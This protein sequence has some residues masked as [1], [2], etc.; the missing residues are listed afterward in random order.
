[1]KTFF[2]IAAVALSISANAQNV[3]IPDINFKNALLE[4]NPVIDTNGDNEIQVSEAA[5]FNG[6]MHISGRDVTDL[7]GIEAFTALETLFCTNNQLT[8]LNI[9]SNTALKK[10]DCSSNQLTSLDVSN[11]TALTSLYCNNNELTGLDVSNNTALESLV[12]PIN[13]LTSL[14]VSNNIALTYLY[15]SDNP[16]SGLDI[17]SN[18]ALTSLSCS[19]N[20]LISLDLTNNTD[21]TYLNCVNN[22]LTSLNTSHNTFLTTLFCSINQLTTL[23][24]SANTALIHLDCSNNLL[25]NLDVSNNT[26]LTQ[27]DCYNNQ[28]SGLDVSNNT[29]LTSLTCS[30]NPLA[31]LDVSNNVALTYLICSNNQLT[32]LDV[33]NNIVLTTLF[34]LSN[35][36]TSLNVANTNN[37]NFTKFAAAYN[38]DLICIKVDNAQYSIANWTPGANFAF[39]AGI[40]FSE[41]CGSIVTPTALTATASVSSLSVILNWTDNAT[42]EAGYKVERSTDGVNFTEIENL[43]VNTIT[44][45]DNNVLASTTYYYRVY[46]YNI[47]MNSGFSNVAQVT[48]GMTGVKEINNDITVVYPNPADNILNIEIKERSGIKIINILGETIGV[49]QLY[50]GNNVVDIS[51]LTQ[52]IYFIHH[53]KGGSVKFV[54]E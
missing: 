22:Q 16:L 15:C 27:L 8:S 40:S 13:Q 49:H 54:K 2:F 10:L 25:T 43:P 5:A 53:E 34:C 47:G 26:I 21:L 38:P 19:S 35:Q 37:T 6:V 31:T 33:S 3:N 4:H 52:G 23:T 17:S 29:S 36:L 18:T 42:T 32:T 45:I 12:C 51:N 41:D 30:S 1:M 39:D 46:A 11:N 50:T 9:S 24:V 44:T 7:T 14:D 28:L 48:T 20:G